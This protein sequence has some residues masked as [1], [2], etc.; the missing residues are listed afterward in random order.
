MVFATP[1][2]RFRMRLP[3]D[4]YSAKIVLTVPVDR[5]QMMLRTFPQYHHLPRK[6][7]PLVRSTS[8]C[9]TDIVLRPNYLGTVIKAAR[10]CVAASSSKYFGID[11]EAGR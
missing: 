7:S 2:L 10:L 8:L 6:G 11:F 4:E 3:E 9:C 1:D 5:S